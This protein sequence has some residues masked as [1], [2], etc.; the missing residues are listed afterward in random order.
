MLCL[1]GTTS[2]CLT[3]CF[4]SALGSG[5]IAQRCA[6]PRCEGDRLGG[7][8]SMMPSTGS[9]TKAIFV[10]ARPAG[11]TESATPVCTAESNHAEIEGN[12]LHFSFCAHDVYAGG[13]GSQ[14][15]NLANYH[16]P[17]CRR[18]QWATEPLGMRRFHYTAQNA[19]SIFEIILRQSR[20]SL[21]QCDEYVR[22]VGATCLTINQ[23]YFKCRTK[24]RS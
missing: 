16:L 22:L 1:R 14:T 9:C 20:I 4:D 8:R 24:S 5:R 11:M 2:G 23:R 15:N 10:R 3:L 6:P 19:R 7:A 13:V 18:W 12:F 17:I 21:I